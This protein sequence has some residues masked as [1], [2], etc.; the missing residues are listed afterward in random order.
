[1]SSSRPRLSG[2]HAHTC[3]MHTRV[4]CSASDYRKHNYNVL[5]VEITGQARPGFVSVRVF[6]RRFKCPPKFSGPCCSQI[7]DIISI[8]ISGFFTPA[9]SPRHRWDTDKCAPTPRIAYT[10][11]VND[12]SSSSFHRTHVFERKL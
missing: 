4:T 2:D 5:T 8:P 3:T 10:R 6:L 9:R 1:M 11:S 7:G 12:F